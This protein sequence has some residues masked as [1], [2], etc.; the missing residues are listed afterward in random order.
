MSTLVTGACGRVGTALMD[1][2]HAEQ[3]FVYFD[4]VDHPAHT[5]QTG[6]V[7]NYPTVESVM[8]GVD[9]VIHLAAESRVDASW[10]AVLQTNIIGSYN[11]FNAARCHE[12][13]TLVFA[14]SNHVVGMY[15]QEYSPDLYDAEYD[16][17]LTHET[18]VRPDSHYATSKVCN[19]AH[20]RY[21]V[22]NF[23]YPEQVYVL[24][25]GSIRGPDGDHPYADAERG[26][27]RGEWERESEAYDREV[28]R[29]KA[30][31]QSRRDLAAM[32]D[33]CLTNDSVTYDIFY[34]VSDN[35]RRWFDID[36][37]SDTIGYNPLDNGEEWDGPPA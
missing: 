5:V 2:L 15:E 36:H 1:H 30:T 3:D 20:A 8:D 13:G 18:P 7:A 29:M 14:S 9:S 11:V 6:D 37:A 35:D 12:V 24:R 33:A 27:Q 26:V 22:E 21:Y 32:V 4:E 34:G 17:T 19:E 16:L 25:L 28:Q 31:W 23:E 10:P